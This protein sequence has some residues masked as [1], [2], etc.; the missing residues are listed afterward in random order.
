MEVVHDRY[1]VHRRVQLIE[2]H[3]GIPDHTMIG[4]VEVVAPDNV[5]HIHHRLA[6]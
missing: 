4:A 3:H 1:D 6:T 5:L 2:L